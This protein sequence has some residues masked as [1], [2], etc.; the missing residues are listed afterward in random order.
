MVQ[1][2]IDENKALYSQTLSKLNKN[3]IITFSKHLLGYEIEEAN[4]KKKHEIITEVLDIAYRENK[5]E[6]IDKLHEV[7]SKLDG[8]SIERAKKY[9][10]RVWRV[11]PETLENVKNKGSL[12]LLLFELNLIDDLE[13]LIF[14]ATIDKSRLK[15]QYSLNISERGMLASKEK[16]EKALEEF[17]RFWN[18]QFID[19]LF[20]ELTS[21]QENPLTVMISISKESGR[22]VIKQ[23]KARVECRRPRDVEDFKRESLE[24][25]PLT[26]R[27]IYIEE[28]PNGGYNV[29]FNF[30]PEKEPELVETLFSHL[31]RKQVKFD[32]FV[33]YIPEV[34]HEME[35]KTN[36]IVLQA[37]GDI[38]KMKTE[39]AKLKEKALRKVNQLDVPESK[40]KVI[41]EIIKEFKILPPGILDD[42]NLAITQIIQKGD[43]DIY[44]KHPAGRKLYEAGFELAEESKSAKKIPCFTIGGRK[45]IEVVNGILK[46][47]KKLSETEWEAIKLIFSEGDGG[48]KTE[49]QR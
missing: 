48:E 22:K 11:K 44:T 1:A 45:Y 36:Q 12:A 5:L 46:S 42:P 25:Y 7:L 38:D 13:G 32:E 40:K 43:P 9:L 49:L 28:I 6:I 8:I 27:H 21:F 29:I 23:F 17:T 31:L 19:A 30:D 33:R 41:V 10:T 24:I 47:N 35:T 18:N 4:K 15:Y 14:A 26:F 34:V 3:D 39:F 20:A 37:E 2:N 16:V